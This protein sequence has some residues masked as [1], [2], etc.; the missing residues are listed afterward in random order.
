[1]KGKSRFALYQGNRGFFPASLQKSAREELV[2]TLEGRGHEVLTFPFEATKSGGVETIEEGRRYARFLHENRGKYDGVVL[3]LPNF[4]DENGAM[5]AF[6]ECDV[7]IFI[8]AY[9]DD[10]DKMAPAT[11]RDSFCGKMS[12]M[13]VFVQCGIAFTA[14]KPHTVSPASDAFKANIDYFDR[15]CRVVRDLRNLR[16]GALGARTTAFKTVRFDEI[17]LQRHGVT[18]ETYDLSELF[19][20]VKSLKDDDARVNDKAQ[21]LAGYARWDGV[22]DDARLNI[23]KLGVAIDDMVGEYGLDCVAIRCWNELQEQLKVSPCVLASEMNERGVAA[24]CELD[25]GNAIA[26]RALQSASGSPAACLDWNNNYGDDENKCVLFHC[27]P[28]PKSMLTDEGRIEEHAILATTMGSGCT[29]GCDV[30]RIKPADMTYGSLLTRDG[31]IQVFLG[32]ARF[33]GDPIP[34]D[35]FGCAGVAEFPAMQEM[36]QQIGY[37][38]FRHHVSVTTGRHLAPT[39]EAMAKYLGYKVM[40]F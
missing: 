40:L 2:K 29:F 20:R 17:A 39:A 5:A 11:R 21:A 36:L 18:T 10:L 33:T 19:A 9:P 16:V 30:G 15:M 3:A 14:L 26:M 31:G 34:A 6:G 27:G 32:E 37:S 35:F 12:I 28:V 7:P 4:G 1:M 22:P 38:G 23:A 24:S 13:D 25:V 8:Q